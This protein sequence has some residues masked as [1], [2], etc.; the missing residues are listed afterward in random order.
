MRRRTHFLLAALAAGSATAA[1]LARAAAPPAPPPS[2]SVPA[3]PKLEPLTWGTVERMHRY[4]GIYLASQ[5]SKEDLE[6][7][8]ESGVRTVVNL[9]KPAEIDWDEKAAVEGLGME[10][11][12][13]GFKEPEELTDG[14]LDS[15]RKIL[16]SGDR[17][18]ILLHCSSAN[19]VGAVWL[20]HRV[21][22]DAVPYPE[23][24]VEAETVGMK[25]AAFRDRVKEYIERSRR[26]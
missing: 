5:P 17:N 3:S 10:Y 15:V 21:L 12:N 2:V 18:P 13:F 23:A 9:R 7:A 14:V 11:D 8:R 20:A 26:R 22:D 4:D 25:S 19:R 6:L 24:L 1:G 16:S